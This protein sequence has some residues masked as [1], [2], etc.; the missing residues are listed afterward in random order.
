MG[1]IERVQE[2]KMKNTIFLY[3]VIL[4]V[5]IYLI[6]TFGIKLLLNTSS[7][8]SGLFPQPSV[9]PSTKLE[10]GI[11]SVD[12]YSIPQ[13]TNSA[14][15]I[16][17]GSTLNFDILEFYI[18]G[19]KVKEKE[20]VADTFSEEIGDLEKGNNEIYIKAKSK[21][22]K[23]EKNTIIYKVFYKNEKPK[24]EILEPTDN[25]TTNN[26]DIKV[27]GN[28]GKET[29]IRVNDSPVVV[30]VNGNFET[31]VRLKD[32]ENQIQITAVDIAVN[33]ESK[34]VK[35]IYQKD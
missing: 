18:N 13:A 11:N 26:Q 29:Y 7:F 10:D 2:K 21:E 23:T 16:V 34:T 6:F 15:I 24:I 22:S 31:S 8:I 28:T 4:F 1:R 32:G 27:K 12:V 5:V 20:S 17:S 19:K 30:D 25:F 9:K 3:I 35:V 14:K 33:T